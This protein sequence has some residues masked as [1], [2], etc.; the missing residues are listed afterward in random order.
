MVAQIIANEVLNNAPPLNMLAKHQN[1]VAMALSKVFGVGVHATINLI[2]A[3]GWAPTA[4][5]LQYDATIERIVNG[6][7]LANK[8]M[9]TKWSDLRPLV[10]NWGDGRYFCVNSK[11]NDFGGQG[12]GHAFAIIKAGGWGTAAN[13]SEEKGEEARNYATVMNADHRVSVWGPA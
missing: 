5:A 1:C 8:A 9:N 12:V 2:L 6:L 13:N 4:Q 11:M 10:S 3:K 7:P